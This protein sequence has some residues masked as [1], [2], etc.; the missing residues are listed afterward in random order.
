[1][2]LAVTSESD[3]YHLEKPGWRTTPEGDPRGY[4]QPEGLR[5]LWFH[6]GTLCNLKCSF[7]LEGSKPGDDRV[8]LP[9]FEDIRTYIDEALDLGVQQF[10]F[11]GGEPFVNRDMV[12]VLD[13]ALD[14]RPCLV[15]T[16]ATQPLQKRLDDVKKL[17]N[18]PN[19]L[20]F[21]VSLD[22]P[23]ASAHDAERGEGNF[24]RSLETMRSLIGQGFHVSVARLM[25]NEEDS[26]AV[27][28][29][30]RRVFADAGLPKDLH[31][32]AFPEFLTPCSH[33][34]GVPSI[35]E[36]CMTQYHSEE[37]RARFMCSFSK[38]VLKMDGKMRV[39][40]CTLVDDDP[41]Y[42]LGDSLR[43]SLKFRIMLQH[44]RCFSCFAYGASCS[45]VC[46]A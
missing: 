12:R 35:T 11:T 40:A 23:D 2:S 22:H 14:R 44:H 46:D 42:D 10:S 29:R 39:Y 28:A 34:T 17:A 3:K 36:N 18:K 6:T 32:V 45:E 27:E 30:Y 37:S 25:E 5:E 31:F 16:N 43:E 7:C 19:V 41:D 26:E 38:M 9:S 33:P 15:L 1:M 20:S 24:M 13:Y 21:R 4:I 8:Q